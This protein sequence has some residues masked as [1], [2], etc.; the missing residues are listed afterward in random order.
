MAIVTGYII[1]SGVLY[2]GYRVMAKERFILSQVLFGGGVAVFYIATFAAFN[3][4]HLIGNFLT[5]VGLASASFMA[6]FIA[7]YYDQI[8]IGLI[9]LLGGLLIPFLVGIDYFGIYGMG[10]YLIFISLGGSLIYFFRSGEYYKGPI[11][12]VSISSCF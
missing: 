3:T 9:G 5:I 7:L 1:G 6:F 11:C 8:S 10:L 2:F 12:L 4:Y